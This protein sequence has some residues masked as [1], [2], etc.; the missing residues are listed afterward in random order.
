MPDLTF[1]AKHNGPA[2]APQQITLSGL[3][4][5]AEECA[6]SWVAT[7]EVPVELIF[8]PSVPWLTCVRSSPTELTVSVNTTGLAKQKYSAD[9]HVDIGVEERCATGFRKTL[10]VGLNVTGGKFGWR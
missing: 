2:P 5:G 10:T 8:S 9:L 7:T 3:F 4:N 6:A 1:T